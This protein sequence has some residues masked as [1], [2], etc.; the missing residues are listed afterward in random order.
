MRRL[1]TAVVA[2]VLVTTVAACG[3]DSDDASASGGSITIG[4]LAPLTGPVAQNAETERNI[5]EMRIKQINADGGVDGKTLKLK[6]YD[7]KLDPATAA[8][9]AQRAISQDKVGALIG[10]YTTSEALAVADV[11]E[12]SK[13]VDINNSA[14]SEA[15]TAGKK[16][17]FR[18]S[19]LTRLLPAATAGQ[20]AWMYAA[21]FSGVTPPVGMT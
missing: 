2:A 10:P 17:V 6:V 16:Y 4:L 3:S 11:V 5:V 15:I 21:Q 12:R 9:E 8:Q 19:P 1:L 13:V 20:P 14:A 7:T 18:T